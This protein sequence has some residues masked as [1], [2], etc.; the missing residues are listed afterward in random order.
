MATMLMLSHHAFRR[1]I[2]RFITAM[3]QVKAGDVSRVDALRAEWKMYRGG[4]H[5]HHHIEDTAMFPDLKQKHPEAAVAID[6]LTEDHHHIDPLL[7]RGDAAFANLPQTDEVMVILK[8]LK[9][10]LD[11]HLAHE[12]AEVTPFLRE[13]KEFPVPP[14]D[15]AAAMYAQGFA[16][17][18]QGIAPSVTEELRKIL[19]DSLNAKL[20]EAL[21]AFEER[22]KKTWGTFHVGA[23]TTP[24]PDGYTV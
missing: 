15:E 2:V 16:W 17:S 9:A 3:D 14:N 24:I 19:P 6:Q 21:A 1:D 11:A 20:P 22:S 13:A 4:L 23:A 8:E 10:L 18:M 5:G 12:E 7:E